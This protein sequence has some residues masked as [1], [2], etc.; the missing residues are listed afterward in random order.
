[1]E[2]QPTGGIQPTST[3]AVSIHQEQTTLAEPLT[4][5]VEDDKANNFLCKM[6]LE[7]VG[8]TNLRM[9]FRAD[10]TL[11]ELK[12]MCENK[13]EFPSLILLDINMPAMD[14]WQFLNEFRNFPDEVRNKTTIY[15]F[16]SSDHPND[17][18]KKQAY[19]EVLDFLAKPLSEE[20]ANGLKEK[21]FRP[22]IA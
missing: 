12:K 14:G 4:F 16:S 7:E 11:E 15:L 9:F 13:Q 20:V 10:T 19:P 3:E 1:M 8:I 6:T 5:V 22:R 21:Y 18:E 17:I 2:T